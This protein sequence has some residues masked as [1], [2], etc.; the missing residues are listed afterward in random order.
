M[1]IVE[2]A[3]RGYDPVRAP[4]TASVASG[5]VFRV[6]KAAPSIGLAKSAGTPAM[7]PD[8]RGRRIICKR[9]DGRPGLVRKYAMAVDGSLPSGA[10]KY[11]GVREGTEARQA[12]AEGAFSVSFSPSAR[13]TALARAREAALPTIAEHRSEEEDAGDCAISSIQRLYPDQPTCSLSSVSSDAT[14]LQYYME[15]AEIERASLPQHLSCE[16]LCVTGTL[17]VDKEY[18]YK[19][20]LQSP[21]ASHCKLVENQLLDCGAKVTC[22]S[23]D[24]LET[25]VESGA[26]K[27]RDIVKLRVPRAVR[28][29][30][31][32]Q[33]TTKVDRVVLLML[34]AHENGTASIAHPFMVV[35]GLAYPIILGRD[36]LNRHPFQAAN[37][38]SGT[39]TYTFAEKAHTPV[40][41]ISDANLA[42]MP[43]L[44][45]EPDQGWVAVLRQD[46][47]PATRS[48]CVATVQ[49]MHPDGVTPIL[50]QPA[51]KQ[52]EVQYDHP[53]IAQKTHNTG[54]YCSSVI[55]HTMPTD[56]TV[57]KGTIVGRA[58]PQRFVARDT[59][60][61][62]P[63]PK[64]ATGD[65][66]CGV[67]GFSHGVRSLLDVRLA[68]DKDPNACGIY[69][70]N[71]PITELLQG[72]LC[73]PEFKEQFITRAIALGLAALIGGPP[74]TNFSMAGGRLS[75]LGMECLCSFLEIA[76]RV[77]TIKLGVLENVMGLL[78]TPELQLFI[79]LA[80]AHGWQVN[81]LKIDGGSCGLATTRQRV[82]LILTRTSSAANAS[83]D[84]AK[85]LFRAESI[86]EEERGQTK[87]YSV[88]DATHD[89]PDAAGNRR[90][91]FFFE[92]RNATSK[93]VYS[94][95]G[96][97]PTIRSSTWRHTNRKP[98][99]PR[100]PDDTHDPLELSHT[101]DLSWQ[102]LKDI[103]SFDDTFTWPEPQVRDAQG[104]RAA[105]A[106]MLANA[107]P[108]RMAS[109]LLD[110]LLRAGALHV[111]AAQTSQPLHPAA[112]TPPSWANVRASGADAEQKE[113][114]EKVGSDSEGSGGGD[115]RDIDTCRD[116]QM[117]KDA[118]HGY[119]M[120]QSQEFWRV[121]PPTPTPDAKGADGKKLQ[122]PVTMSATH[123]RA[124]KVRRRAKLSRAVPQREGTHQANS[125]EG[126][127]ATPRTTST[128][129]TPS[130]ASTGEPP[131]LG[132]FTLEAAM[133]QQ[134]QRRE[135]LKE[136]L[137]VELNAQGEPELGPSVSGGTCLKDYVTKDPAVAAV[138]QTAREALSDFMLEMK[139][140]LGGWSADQVS[141][142]C[143]LL[144]SH[145]S[146]FSRDKW[147]IGY[148]DTLPF[149]ITLRED[150]KPV[151][152]RP[153]R[154]SPR[155]TELIKVEIDKLLA[156]GI[157]RPSLSEWASPV[158]AVLKPDGTARI[159][160]NY[161]KL[162]AMTIIPQMPL[163]NIEDILNSLGGSRIFT[164]MDI[165][166]GYFTSAISEDTIPLTAMVT[167]FGLYEWL[168]CPQGAASAP[169]HFTRLM[170]LVL[171]GLERVQPFI[172]DVIV[173][174]GSV[175]QHLE[176]LEGLFSRLSEHGIKLAPKKVHI[177]CKNVKFLG[178]IVGVDGIRADPDKVKALLLMPV[179]HDL[180][181]LR[182]WLGLA[183]YYRR[184][185]KGMAKIIAPLTLLTGKDVPFIMGPKQLAAMKQVNESLA[186]HTLMRY[187]DYEAATSGQRPFILATDA[188]KVGFGAVL[189]QKDELGT[190][191]PIAFASRA[192]LQNEKNWSVTD[193]EAGA[194]VFGVKKF[195]HMLW[196]TPFIL[197]TD[198]RALQFIE[199]M[200]DKTARGAR[201]HEF[202]TAFPHTIQYR[203]GGKNANAD[204]PSRNPLPADATDREEALR[205]EVAEAYSLSVDNWE[206][207]E[208]LAMCE[209][210]ALTLAMADALGDQPIKG[211]PVCTM[212][213]AQA[214]KAGRG[215][216]P[217]APT[218]GAT[219]QQAA[220]QAPIKPNFA[221]T[222]PPVANATE[223]S[224]AAAS[225][226]TATHGGTT[227][228]T[229]PTPKPPMAASAATPQAEC[230]DTGRSG[231]PPSAISPPPEPPATATTPVANAAEGSAATPAATASKGAATLP[232]E[233]TPTSTGL[234]DA[235]ASPTHRDVS[236]TP[237]STSRYFSRPGWHATEKAVT[238]SRP[239]HSTAPAEAA[240][241]SSVPAQP[242]G[243]QKTSGTA[244]A[245]AAHAPTRVQGATPG[246]T[247]A[248]ELP[249]G[250]SSTAA[251]H[252]ASRESSNHTGTAATPPKRGRAGAVQLQVQAAASHASPT[253]GHAG[254]SPPPERTTESHEDSTPTAS[255]TPTTSAQAPAANTA[256]EPDNSDR[257][258]TSMWE[259]LPE[260]S[261]LGDY[262]PHDWQEAQQHDTLCQH[263]ITLLKTGKLPEDEPAA[264]QSRLEFWA[265]KC[266]L[267][268][269]GAA[270]LL[271]RQESS[272]DEP[273]SHS[274]LILQLVIP[275]S[276][277]D[278][279]LN[280]FHNTAW[281]GHQGTKRTM[282]HVRSH[283][284]WPGWTASAKYWCEHCASCQARKR[285]GKTSQL[286]TVW[287]ELPPH[288]FHTIALDFFGPLPTS[289][290]GAKYVLVAQDLYSRW[291]ETY[292]ITP[293]DMSSVGVARVLVD[294][295]STQHG[296]PHTLLSDRGSQFMS[297]LAKSVYTQMGCR[298][299][300]TTA[301]H[302]QCNGMVERFMQ[303]LAAQL[304]LVVS[305]ERADW[306]QW[307]PHVTFAYN[308]S[309]HS[310][311]GSTPFL[312]ATGREPRL[313]LHTIFGGL[314][315][316]PL[317][318]SRRAPAIQ[319]ILE[320]MLTRQREAHSLMHKRHQL[321]LEHVLRTDAALADAM[322]LKPRYAVGEKAYWHRPLRTKSARE[323]T[324]EDPKNMNV[325]S[326][327]FQ[328]PWGGPYNILQVGPS[329]VNNVRVQANNL[330]LD[331]DGAP[332]RANMLLCKPFRDPLTD[333][334]KPHHLPDGFA[335]YLLAYSHHGTP[336]AISLE[337]V[338]P[339]AWERH[340]VESIRNHRLRRQAHNQAA[341]LEYLVQWEG[342]N[343]TDSWE[344][345]H[346]LDAC[347]EV[348]DEYW[349]TVSASNTDIVGKG[350]RIV[351]ENIRRANR[352]YG[353]H[354]V[355][356]NCP[357][358][359][360]IGLP[361]HALIVS[362][363]PSRAAL[364]H[365]LMRKLFILQVWAFEQG[366]DSEYKRWCEG[367][368][369][370]LPGSGR[371]HTLKF[372][373][374]RQPY[375]MRL[376]TPELPYASHNMRAQDAKEGTWLLIGTEE[377]VKALAAIK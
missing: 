128:K 319:D 12:V 76:T 231:A 344:P 183:N 65:V 369:K 225:A 232:A 146:T 104:G 122:A 237:T 281:A 25:L 249:R 333:A 59:P 70:A 147:D 196:G 368:I 377:Q 42:G 47:K 154:Y 103:S 217:P 271:M 189:S 208:S 370:R 86:V 236:G 213:R 352:E 30:V 295:Y 126:E 327:K 361:P 346:Y 54:I 83:H 64:L 282:A 91:Y 11:W 323:P 356:C 27:A 32:S 159:T 261:T 113:G 191:Q 177:G 73:N 233:S 166:S 93:Q 251:T 184:F 215:S 326:K 334:A 328:Y 81:I 135:R 241:A 69:A 268:P 194:I 372:F 66:F 49:I 102:D 136:Q 101:Y 180:S 110:V 142:L 303:T 220:Q 355:P 175:D 13:L 307:L 198:H 260:D 97:A 287:R 341:Q 339:H 71:H 302:P 186:L 190:E 164:T 348:V 239:G 354:G 216:V 150:S 96:T 363:K 353:V 114:E 306:D 340:G 365:P 298:K 289:A 115:P 234:A 206:R 273:D 98:Y 36:F 78:S 374:D 111:A 263:L 51:D 40:A 141:R 318:K 376:L 112:W 304:T 300:S 229:E 284:W 85:A 1:P 2:V 56:E 243:Q 258:P 266:R 279:V 134:K 210:I 373:G 351:Q 197:Y 143:F 254:E 209:Y 223:G 74:C 144:K 88:R 60:L 90:R 248:V 301:Y 288:A 360:A 336:P 224:A 174:S 276:L 165:T 255:F 14:V 62:Q 152:D 314:M 80:S 238:R 192:T 329:T 162:N 155:F 131:P 100:S 343:V 172:D 366:L 106:Q 256:E 4:P 332:T 199:T 55:M 82:F 219:A 43:Q 48:Y 157:I 6:F 292:A 277:R 309:E 46:L 272:D 188:S 15:L 173:H 313:A 123:G 44:V 324:M 37:T 259:G 149:H 39:T 140:E 362:A 179:P 311:T 63:P 79:E 270:E 87:G 107:V 264:Y 19:A 67:G 181:S 257:A 129:P 33:R 207:V 145:E 3:R 168:R 117:G 18:N 10:A 57:P 124:K 195:R 342:D 58:I 335:K 161:R 130:A 294:Q 127:T 178:H 132:I 182:A 262:T 265:R 121:Q 291:V 109:Y 160:V 285:Y 320:S 118:W 8:A 24:Q 22:I 99:T 222:S 211:A 20:T 347:R 137:G 77:P 331:V 267:Q 315:R 89:R 226:A 252:A 7:H 250:P 299:L 290:S 120:S 17:V 371:K 275:L 214:R 50:D 246:T 116:T 34:N 337:D 5:G 148:C 286:P 187:P 240:P 38:G 138:L 310:Q 72:D 308:A 84:W 31:G 247:T 35:P 218:Q 280:C 125:Q 202:L 28:G 203:E 364:C 325:F 245:T 244:E 359:E 185:I 151:S 75:H 269:I 29:A 349:K 227:S 296:S 200:R 357:P 228:T 293:E 45:D 305:S 221:G 105:G 312:L 201:W 278:Q 176:D 253:Q 167:S 204:G 317:A 169:G 375:E 52:V 92:G 358:N 345:A 230:D 108:P 212:T 235:T 171:R 53:V 367:V 242:R 163:P 61:W 350:T 68:A 158:V 95:D 205:E 133:L 21:H 321:R 26:V 283:A 322:G 156:A 16:H 316:E 170:A 297:E 119:T 94:M 338:K 330:L 274:S 193:L 153:Y 23:A 139:V 41:S 9:S